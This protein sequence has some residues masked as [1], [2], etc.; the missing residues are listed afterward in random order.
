VGLFNAATIGTH[1]AALMGILSAGQQ[2]GP[3]RHGAEVKL[4]DPAQPPH[5]RSPA[6]GR[7]HPR[8]GSYALQAFGRLHPRLTHRGGW[9]THPGPLP[10]IEGTVIGVRVERL[11]G[12][13]TPKP[14][15]LWHSNPDPSQLDLPRLFA[16]FLRRFDLE[17]TF[18]FV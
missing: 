6:P 9:S 10:I 17:H 4:A 3:S 11:P 1:N 2:P 7:A 14:L 18:R 8:Y 13:R 16:A 15:W 12:D 5:A